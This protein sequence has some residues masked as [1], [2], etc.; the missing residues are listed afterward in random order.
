MCAS[1]NISFI[2]LLNDCMPAANDFF[3][4]ASSY[5]YYLFTSL[6]DKDLPEGQG[7]EVAL[8]HEI[9]VFEM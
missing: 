2:G 6:Q 4:V 5:H 3:S 8:E 7:C 9:S 1:N